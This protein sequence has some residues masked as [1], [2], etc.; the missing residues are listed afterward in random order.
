MQPVDASA[1]ATFM[2]K[3]SDLEARRRRIRFR[4]T[5]RGMKETDILLG[6]LAR[7]ELDDLDE[8]GLSAFERLLEVPDA[9]IL[10]WVSGTQ[11]VPPEH[12]G[13]L[14][15]RLRAYVFRPADY[16]KHDT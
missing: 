8:A 4:A 11:A 2:T 13:P 6:R 5:H 1:R 16:G 7:E 9:D 15:K 12:D 10:A 14:I 3:D